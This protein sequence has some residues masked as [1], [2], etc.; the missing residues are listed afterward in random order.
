MIKMQAPTQTKEEMLVNDELMKIRMA[1]ELNET[2][3]NKNTEY[4]LY[5][6]ARQ[7]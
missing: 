1:N 7:C 6:F 2:Q 5:C 3:T 4:W